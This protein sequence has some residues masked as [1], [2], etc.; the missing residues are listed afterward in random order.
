MPFEKKILIVDDEEANVVLLESIL[1]HAGYMKL[2]SA[3]DPRK[4]AALAA[5]FDPDLVLLDLTMPYLDGFDVMALLRK[6]SPP[7][8]FLPILV[9]TADA[10]RQTR[11]RALA[12]GANDFLTKPFENEEVLLRC[13]NL[14]H[15][16]S[17][18]L[19]LQDQN[20]QLEDKV[21][22]RTRDLEQALTDLKAS[23]RQNLQQERLR[24]L[25]EMSGGVAHDF[26]NR[27]TVILGYSELL[28][29]N[30]AQMLSN[31][32]LAG[33]YLKTMNDAARES[34][35]I[36]GRLREFSRRREANDV[37]LTVDLAR[38]VKEAAVLTQP[39]WKAQAQA[40]GRNIIARLELDP[41][42]AVAGNAAELRE[43]L[44][45]LILNAVDAMPQGGAITLRT[46]RLG[47]TAMIEVGDTGVGMDEE[48][49]RRCLEPFFTTKG[50][51]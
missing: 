21:A 24:A 1:R 37:F 32:L 45:H 43:A 29:L 10:T 49:Q 26:N 48:V 15:A 17:L 2:A 46:R 38:L 19:R 35:A 11:R 30:N 22:Q 42:P 51:P 9:L 12:I 14:L 20:H 33:Q 23:Q 27:L 31:K 34:T 13:N 5:E 44:S 39:K 28:L 7:D 8:A 6:A 36:V 25:G 4:V 40:T 18:H 41:V 50:F 47:D 3:S 16:R